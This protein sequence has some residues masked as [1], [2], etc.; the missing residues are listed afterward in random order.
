M[1]GFVR[2]KVLSQ[3]WF[4]TVSLVV[5]EPLAGIELAASLAVDEE[6]MLLVSLHPTCY[7]GH[8]TSEPSIAEPPAV[9]ETSPKGSSLGRRLELRRAINRSS[10]MEGSK[11]SEAVFDGNPSNIPAVMYVAI[12]IIG[13]PLWTTK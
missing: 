13:S 5:D 6:L 10:P 4:L 1:P 7:R 11:K 9:V 2:S 3:G 12:W 8:T